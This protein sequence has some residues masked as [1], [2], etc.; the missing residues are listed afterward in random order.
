M[1]SADGCFSGNHCI[2]IFAGMSRSREAAAVSI[3]SCLRQ[4]PRPSQPLH[5]ARPTQDPRSSQAGASPHQTM[6]PPPPIPT[7]SSSQQ[8]HTSNIS[9]PLHQ[10]QPLDHGALEPIGED[11]D[12]ADEME[13]SSPEI[14]IPPS[15]AGPEAC[16][17]HNGTDP[18]EP[19]QHAAGPS[20]PSRCPIN[21]EQLQQQPFARS[22]LSRAN[23]GPEAFDGS[24]SSSGAPSQQQQPS[25]VGGQASAVS[26]QQCSSDPASGID[27]PKQQQQQ[28]SIVGGPGLPDAGATPCASHAAPSSPNSGQQH[29]Q[30]NHPQPGSSVRAADDETQGTT[31]GGDGVGEQQVW[32]WRTP[33]E[34]TQP[35]WEGW[36]KG[37]SEAFLKVSA[38]KVLMLAGTDRL[39]KPLMV[40]QMQGRFQLSL[41][42]Q[43]PQPLCCQLYHQPTV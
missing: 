39:D 31:A 1:G 11:D 23:S 3:P 13:G 6:G 14:H 27:H 41:L 10:V 21:P 24:S 29:E 22:G 37:L 28:Q 32:V 5:D 25:E 19:R 7:T 35:F 43:V 17:A 20:T 8:L 40:G 30:H 42:P 15:S 34:R 9:Y 12:G 38:P 18:S 26:M 4:Q 33:L 36:Y 16:A 2:I